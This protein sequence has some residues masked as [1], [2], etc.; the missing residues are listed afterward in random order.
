M[1]AEGLA[2]TLGRAPSVQVGQCWGPVLGGGHGDSKVKGVEGLGASSHSL[3]IP[4][5]KKA[6]G[7]GSV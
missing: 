3:A 2:G 1:A 4:P 5:A 6:S 7:L